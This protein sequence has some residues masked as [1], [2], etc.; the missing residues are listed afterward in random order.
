MKT[1][2]A[3]FYGLTALFTALLLT[4]TAGCP[5]PAGG[6]GGGGGETPPPPPAYD[7]TGTITGDDAGD[8]TGASVQL[9]DSSNIPVGD[10]VPVAADGSYTIPSVEPGTGYYIEV[11]RTGYEIAQTPPFT[12]DSGDVPGINLELI[13]N[14]EPDRY[15]L[16]GGVT[17]SG[18]SGVITD[19][20]VQLLNSDNAPVGSP[21]AVAANGS[22]AIPNVGRGSYRVKVT[23][24][25]YGEVQ[26]GLFEVPGPLV[27]NPP[28]LTPS[29]G[30]TLSGIIFG[31]DSGDMAGALVQ[32]K[33]NGSPVGN[34]VTAESGGAYTIYNVNEGEGYTI[35]VTY[36]GYDPFESPAFEVTGNDSNKTY[37]LNKSI[38]SISGTI[39]GDDAGDMT[40]ASVQLKQGGSNY[41]NAVAA[42]TGGAYTITGVS[43]G[44][45]YTIR[46]THAGYDPFETPAFEVTG[47]GT[48]KD[49]IL[50]KATCTVSG[51]ISGSDSGDMSGASVQ[52]KQGGSPVGSPVTAA[53]GGIYTI[54]GVN[55]GSGYTVAASHTGYRDNETS[56]FEV[57]AANVTGRNITLTKVFEVKGTISGG[58]G[59]SVQL[60]HGTSAVGDPVTTG[61]DGTYVIPN[62]EP[63]TGYYVVATKAG[64]NGAS[65]GVFTVDGDE[66]GNDITLASGS[67]QYTVWGQITKTDSGAMNGTDAQIQVKQNGSPVGSPVTAAGGQYAI[68]VP[69][70]TGYTVEASLSGYQT[71]S[72]SA[73]AAP[74]LLVH[75]LTLNPGTGFTVTGTIT[76]S[77]TSD[78]LSGASVQLKQS[79]SNV[80]S[81]VTTDGDGEYS[82]SGVIGGTYTIGVTKAAYNPGES[83][84]FTVPGTLTQDLGLTKTSYSISGTISGDDSG[85][86]SGA[87]VQLKQSGGN[88]GSPVTAAPGGAYT[89][90]GVN[91]GTG[92][93]I[94]VSK[95]G[96][97]PGV[98]SSF[99]VAAANVSGKNLTLKKYYTIAGTITGDIDGPLT[100]ASVQLKQSGGNVG[101]P[102][103]A[104]GGAYTI[105]NVLAG[106]GYTV[107]ASYAGYTGNETGAFAVSSANITNKD[108]TLAK[109]SYTV[110]GTITGTDSGNMSGA[111]VQLKQGSSPVGS[112]V[113]AT[114]GGAYTITGVYP[115]SYTVAASHTGYTGNETETFAVTS[116]NVS[117]K[118][119]TLT[120]ITYTVSGTITGT[121]SGNMSGASVQLKQGGSPVGS[122]VTAAAGGTYTI[123]GVNP[124]ND[125]TVAAS[126]SGY[127]GNET[128]V[129][130][131]TSNV[132][133][134]DITLTKIT[135]TV[136]GT[137]IGSDSGNMSG[138]S[139]Q[140]K[141]GGLPV[142]SPVTA[143]AGGTYTITGVNP[144]AGY[145]VVASHSGY[146][147]NE[148]GPFAV[149]SNVTGKDITL[150][151]AVITYTISG[152]VSGTSGG[153]SGVSVQLRQAGTN[154]GSPVTTTGGSYTITG[155][156]EG[157]GYTLK[158][159]GAGY[160]DYGTVPFAVTGNITGKNFAMAPDISKQDRNGH[161]VE[162]ILYIEAND[163]D[164]R[165]AMGYTM[166]NSGKPFFDYVIL[167]AAN[168][169]DRDTGDK[170]GVHLYFNSN[171]KYILDNRNTYIKPLQDKGIRVLLGLLGDHDDVGFGYFGSHTS[172]TIAERESFLQEVAEAVDYYGLD[173]VDFDDE[174]PSSGSY[175][176]TYA[177][178]DAMANLIV[179]T[180]RWLGPDKVITVYDWNAAKYMSKTLSVRRETS[181]GYYYPADMTPPTAYTTD[182]KAIADFYNYSTEGS[183]GEWLE[184]GYGRNGNSSVKT[185]SYAKSPTAQYAPVAMNLRTK[186]PYP[187]SMFDD[188]RTFFGTGSKYFMNTAHNGAGG[189]NPY[190]ANMF[191]ALRELSFY[192]SHLAWGQDG[193][194]DGILAP[195]GY[196]TYISTRVYNENVVYMGNDYPKD[197]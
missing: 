109:I 139:V 51:A 158:A 131:V 189:A 128:G 35:R 145:T 186:I 82:I 134:K 12:V 67:G 171:V 26:T 164:P 22:Y 151:V 132:T 174:W 176:T 1:K 75:N 90:T 184:W 53:A 77:I 25:G 48:R 56:A 122:P 180:R 47:D 165:V 157:T 126:H 7:V 173:G 153:L 87:S 88:V 141:Q 38:Y 59:A 50:T 140:L 105:L 95:A 108:L 188:L 118:S 64:Y 9:F 58:P 44:E 98:I 123:T 183:Y 163:T 97:Q 80:G 154:V 175:T 63:R 172:H 72:S 62:V 113:I 147:D 94:E 104:A 135:Y 178:G 29:T 79:G 177:Y 3:L 89:I 68:D 27:H 91:P 169:V 155:V 37:T 8:M 83:G 52:L 185:Q 74:G 46:V 127:T 34:P 196:L 133:G 195:A 14:P 103:T 160:R 181:T 102:V 76:D 71:V 161:R 96:Y 2:R 85:D 117:G 192:T 179:S 23:L 150:P 182:P 32:L 170:S 17:L 10:P 99:D 6:G 36:A 86:M 100:G 16:R 146:N 115:G 41:G 112:P 31:S 144:G 21:V 13:N 20:S 28:S 39:T 65:T 70:G 33:Q 137:I 84:P 193:L 69:A 54:T 5:N 43:A 73:F 92:Y 130:A 159:T 106:S 152:T 93:T 19:A 194:D 162:N 40:G 66:S 167:F 187:E 110:S 129:F 18:G 136:S 197:W 11:S 148:T 15:T 124:G 81:P 49:I 101:S 42:A 116:M 121:D 119:L 55:P 61:I 166:E 107:A 4:F 24:P 45:G 111:S 191:Y 143:T 114:A 149:T 156:P 168:I 190:G 142:G 120:K 125:Y 57:T 60:Y 138:A 30:F 78:P